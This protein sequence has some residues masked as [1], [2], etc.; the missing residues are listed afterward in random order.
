[1][2]SYSNAYVS[3]LLLQT[4]SVCKKHILRVKSNS[5]CENLTLCVETNLV[6]VEITLCVKK[7]HSA[8][9]NQTGVCRNQS[10]DCK[11]LT[12]T[13]QTY[14]RVSRNHTLRVK[15]NSACEN[16]TRCVETNLVRV[17]ITLCV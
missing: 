17:D 2:S 9:R 12:H 13:C 4:Y 3:N 6:R 1:V 11:I 15:S 14:S 10:R 8:C 5:A 7:L 16:L